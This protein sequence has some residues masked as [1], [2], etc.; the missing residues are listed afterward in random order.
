MIFDI[1]FAVIVVFAVAI[2]LH[3]G[4]FDQLLTWVQ[5]F[6]LFIFPGLVAAPLMNTGLGSTFKGM[7]NMRLPEIAENFINS[8]VLGQDFSVWSGASDWLSSFLGQLV[9]QAI[10]FVVML[11]LMIVGFHVAGHYIQKYRNLRKSF[12]RFDTIAGCVFG[13]LIAFGIYVG[14]IALGAGL[15]ADL[16]ADLGL[17]KMINSGFIAPWIYS[18]FTPAAAQP[19]AAFLMMR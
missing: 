15:P 17:E 1:I 19:A 10:I 8:K 3:R 7:F 12:K 6:F 18:W 14:I 2:G 5:I 4:L 13:I 9:L 16:S 11:V